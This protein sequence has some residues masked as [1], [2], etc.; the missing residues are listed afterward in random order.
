MVSNAAA[1]VKILVLDAGTNRASGAIA[2][3]SLPSS[4]ATTSPNRVPGPCAASTAATR[5][6]SDAGS[7]AAI[8][9]G[10]MARMIA[11][12]AVASLGIMWRTLVA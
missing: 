8:G 12:V 11:A 6:G 2:T 7:R 9:I 3:I 4:V 1:V 10:A 5:A